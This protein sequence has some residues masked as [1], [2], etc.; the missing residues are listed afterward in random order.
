[1]GAM[2]R[3]VRRDVP[4]HART[5]SVNASHRSGQRITTR[6][7]DRVRVW[8]SE[9]ASRPMQS[10]HIAW[11]HSSVV[12]VGSRQIGQVDGAAAAGSSRRRFPLRPHMRGT[13]WPSTTGFVLRRPSR[14]ARR[15]AALTACA[16][17]S[18]VSKEPTVRFLPFASRYCA[19]HRRFL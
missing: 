16:A 8:P 12:V 6:R 14:P 11:P 13:S 3:R 4:L 7:R 17:A 9:A 2:G 10:S 19:C 5:R 1:M 18:W 15:M